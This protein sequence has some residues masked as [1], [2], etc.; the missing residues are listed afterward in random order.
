[1]EQSFSL[2]FIRNNLP[3]VERVIDASNLF[4]NRQASDK[5]DR[6]Y[7]LLGLGSTLSA[8]YSLS[9]EEV[10]KH[11][12]RSFI[13]EY[14]GLES[15]LRAKEKSRSSSLPTWVP[16]WCTDVDMECFDAEIGWL[17]IYDF[18]D[19]SRTARAVMKN[20]TSDDVLV[21]KGFAIDHVVTL[22]DSLD[23]GGD[24]VKVVNQ[25][26]DIV[27][28]YCATNGQIYALGGT[29]H[30]A[31]WRTVL[32][33]I[34]TIPEDNGSVY[35]RAVTTDEDDTKSFY[36]SDSTNTREQNLWAGMRFFI[37]RGG[38]IGLA[39]REIEVGDSDFVLL[40]GRMPF[41]LR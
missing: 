34:R 26:Q 36:A 32:A 31:F 29:Y 27:H 21:L 8:D 22:G 40:G 33:D 28:K 20:T 3:G 25:W 41:I 38:L 17:R 6:V 19:A 12:A 23:R 15:L 14:G 35:R 16:D 18:F 37:T 1:M 9:H 11:A 39:T 30:D 7:A 4:R 24:A 10:F 13:S 5:R 2:M